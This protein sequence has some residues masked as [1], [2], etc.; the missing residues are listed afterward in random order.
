MQL[1]ARK[2]PALADPEA[3][4]RAGHVW[5]DGWSSRNPHTMVDV[6]AAVVLRPPR[7][8]R[9]EIK[10]RGALDALSPRVVGRVAL[11]V[12]AAAGG[13]TRALLDAGAKRVYAVDAGHGQLAGSLRQDPRVVNLEATNLGTLDRS[14]VPEV[15]EMVTIDVSYLSLARAVPQLSRVALA[16]DAELVALV[17]PMFELGMAAPPAED[18]LPEAL[19]SAVI[20]I[21]A[22]GWVVRAT[23]RSPVPGS[24]GAVELFVA[25]RRQGL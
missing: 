3:A 7:P 23:M 16:P 13:F 2:F 5:V 14:V 21:E 25:A 8:L 17:K 19:R 4:I 9:G 6:R 18:R 15:I 22:A 24:R 1:I 11:D 20:G 12:G 10:L